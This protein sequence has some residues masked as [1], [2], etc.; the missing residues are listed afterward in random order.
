MLRQRG[1]SGH[2]TQRHTL[3]HK[4]TSIFEAIHIDVQGL[5]LVSVLHLSSVQWRVMYMW[6]ELLSSWIMASLLAGLM[7]HSRLASLLSF[8]VTMS[9][10]P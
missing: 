7:V 10:A 3:T 6:V 8:A 4:R 9:S 2:N 5:V 1:I